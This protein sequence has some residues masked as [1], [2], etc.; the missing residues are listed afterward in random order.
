MTAA[1]DLVEA[2]AALVAFLLVLVVAARSARLVRARWHDARIAP[3]RQE[4]L[5][6]IASEDLAALEGLRRLALAR[7]RLLEPSVLSLTAKLRGESR[8][9]LIALCCELGT[10]ERAL[11]ASRSARAT[12]RAVAA[13]A[14]GTIGTNE[15]VTRLSVLTRDRSAFVRAAAVRALGRSGRSEGVGSLIAALEPGSG[16]PHRFVAQALLRLGEPS[17]PGLIAALGHPHGEV[18]ERAAE[19]LGFLGARSA[20]PALLQAGGSDVPRAL[21]LHALRALGRLG[22]PQAFTVLC[23]AA[24]HGEDEDLR[25][26]AVQALGRLGHLGAVP[27][28]AA[29]VAKGPDRLAATAAESLV[30]LKA[31]GEAAL[32]ELATSACGSAQLHAKAALVFAHR[33]EHAGGPAG[34]APEASS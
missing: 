6:M 33:G 8:R 34:S 12:R 25:R 11:S 17:A 22:A 24:E 3:L 29:V 18:R 19:I 31:P 5:A 9:A 7:W 28:L 2:M 26:L 15:A 21:R 30:A 10:L 4:L 32:S 1:V 14:L 16:V 13:E 20:V 27:I 23:E